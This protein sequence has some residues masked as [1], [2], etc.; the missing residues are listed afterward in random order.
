[1]VFHGRISYFLAVIDPNSFGLVL[2]NAELIVLETRVLLVQERL[3]VDKVL[4]LA[5][6]FSRLTDD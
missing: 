3:R 1:M 5:R 6:F 2:S 4:K